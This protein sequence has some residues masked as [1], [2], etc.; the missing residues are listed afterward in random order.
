MDAAGL[1]KHCEMLVTQQPRACSMMRGANVK[2]VRVVR[3]GSAEL[4]ALSSQLWGQSAGAEGGKQASSMTQPQQ[5]VPSQ[6]DELQ[7]IVELLPRP[8][9]V[10]HPSL[11]SLVEMNT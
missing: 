1:R 11:R 2:R 8:P 4:A 9:A 3:C 5:R 10:L 6:G 7:S